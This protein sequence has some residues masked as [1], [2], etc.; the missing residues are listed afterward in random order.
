VLPSTPS[1][2]RLLC[3]RVWVQCHFLVWPQP[4]PDKHITA[5]SLPAGLAGDYSPGAADEQH[6]QHATPGGTVPV[7]QP[8]GAVM[9]HLQQAVKHRVFLNKDANLMNWASADGCS[10]AAFELIADLV[11]KPCASCTRTCTR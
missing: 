1:C 11:F 6:V 9:H 5:L 4:P 3:Q 10:T 7:S 2:T 8:C